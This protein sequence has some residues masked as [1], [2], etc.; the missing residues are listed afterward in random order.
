MV[1]PPQNARRILLGKSTDFLV[2]KRVYRFQDGLEIVEILGFDARCRRVFF[3]EVHLV[4]HH[5]SRGWA[6]L[7][8]TALITAVGLAATLIAFAAGGVLVGFLFM[9][10]T[11]LPPGAA[12]ALRVAMGVD[13]V[14][15]HGQRTKAVMEFFLTKQRAREVFQQVCRL[16]RERHERL[17][18]DEAA[19]SARSPAGFATPPE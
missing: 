3:D 19:A 1:P 8:V 17:R 16:V 12:F 18:R 9:G 4:T 10:L 2:R 15:V 7:V 6:F 5:Q 11:L 14:T 13:V